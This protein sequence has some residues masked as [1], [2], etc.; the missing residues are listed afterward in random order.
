M[1][2]KLT[3]ANLAAA[4]G[5][6]AKRATEKDIKW[7]HEGQE[8]EAE[9]NVLP[10]SYT[11]VRSDHFARQIN[12]DALAARIACCIVDEEGSPVFTVGDVT[13]DADPERGPLAVG[14]TNELL[15]VIGEVSA[16]GKTPASSTKKPTSGT[17][18]S[19]RGS[20]AGRSKKPKSASATPSS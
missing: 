8:F 4:G 9:V 12:G 18:S 7:Q 2:M 14:L 10:M 1:T 13:G 11:T 17:S 16:L 19:S 3:V 5:F 6:V 15:R 20:A